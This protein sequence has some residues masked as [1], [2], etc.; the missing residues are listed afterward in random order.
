VD[1]EVPLEEVALEPEVL[2]EVED[3][4]S[5]KLKASEVSLTETTLVAKKVL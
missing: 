5:S 3:E 2:V 1:E 4:L